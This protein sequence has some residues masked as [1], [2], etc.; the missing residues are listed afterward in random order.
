MPAKW[1]LH[2]NQIPGQFALIAASGGAGGV[3]VWEGLL[4]LEIKVYTPVLVFLFFILID[5]V[6]GHMYDLD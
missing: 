1:R 3:G 2:A 5:R 6:K 4:Q